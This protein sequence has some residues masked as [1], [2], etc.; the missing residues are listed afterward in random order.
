MKTI[1]LM[2]MRPRWTALALLMMPA[3]SA[4]GW[5]IYQTSWYW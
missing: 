3:L 2:G 1:D 4:A 5:L